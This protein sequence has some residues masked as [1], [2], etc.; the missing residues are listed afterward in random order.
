MKVKQR[1]LTRE[2]LLQSA[3]CEMHRQGYQA[4]SVSNILEDTALTKGAFYHH[5]PTKQALGLAVVEEVIG[6][7]LDSM[8]FT[9]LR[10]SRHPVETLLDIISGIDKKIAPDFIMLGCPL[11]NLMQEM[12]PLDPVFKEK[13]NAV[14]NQW[15]LTVTEAL[16]MGQKQGVIKAEIDCNA[17]ALF[18]VSAWEGCIGIAKSLQSIETFKLCMNQLHG[19]VQGLMVVKK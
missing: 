8:I 12:S 6:P 15:R 18:V 9:P 7:R 10:E 4:A 3:F 19:Y 2:K 1:D 13:L 11:N 5:F 14:I 16:E 17:A